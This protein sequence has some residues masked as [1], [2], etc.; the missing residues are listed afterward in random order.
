MISASQRISLLARQPQ[1]VF[2]ARDLARLWNIEKENTLNGLL[3]RYYKKGLLFR[4]YKGLYSLQAPEKIDPFL[5]GVKALHSYAYVSTET[6]LVRA[7]AMTQMV[8]DITLVSNRSA[9][10]QIGQHSYLSRQLQDKYLYNPAGIIQENGIFKATPERAL[11][12]LWYFN[13]KAY[14]DGQD[15][16]DKEKIRALQKEIG[17][18]LT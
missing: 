7:G 12:D 18:P 6:I 4:I 10:F 13:P 15:T 2:H 3:S 9:R 5:L 16:F 17:Y 8:Y 11:A 1:T 14:I